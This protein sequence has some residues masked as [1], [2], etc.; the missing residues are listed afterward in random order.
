MTGRADCSLHIWT[1]YNMTAWYDFWIDRK[2][3]G[4]YA[5]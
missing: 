5:A 1:L 2:R 4:A 3:V